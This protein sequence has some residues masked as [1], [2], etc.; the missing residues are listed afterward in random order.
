MANFAL[1][2]VH[3]P[4]WDDSRPIREQQAWDAHS[5]F[6]DGLVEDGTILL[7]GPVGDGGHTMHLVEASAEGD[8]RARLGED[9]WARMGLLKIGTIQPWSL[10]LDGRRRGSP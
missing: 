10:W 2:L 3:G 4:A 8:I 5:D 7:G 1:T 9:P 6:M